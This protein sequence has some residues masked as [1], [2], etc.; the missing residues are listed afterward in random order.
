MIP[1]SKGMAIDYEPENGTREMFRSIAHEK[2]NSILQPH[3][4]IFE[5]IFIKYFAFPHRN[6][7]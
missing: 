3:Y 6:D 7:M 2:V 4:E 1:F 5:L